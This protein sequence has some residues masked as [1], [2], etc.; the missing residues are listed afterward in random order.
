MPVALDYHSIYQFAPPEPNRNVDMDQDGKLEFACSGINIYG[1]YGPYTTFFS[2]FE[3]TGDNS[4][5]EVWTD[6]FDLRYP[7]AVGYPG[8][9]NY[10]AYD[11]GIGDVDGDGIDE[12]ICMDGYQVS[13]FKSTGD[14]QYQEI[15][16]LDLPSI[17]GLEHYDDV[18]TILCDV[19]QNGYAEIVLSLGNSDVVGGNYQTYIYEICGQANFGGLTAV[20]R[21][22][23]VRVEWSTLSQYANRGFRLWRAVGGDYGY[24]VVYETNDTVKLSLDTLRYS[25]ND[26]SVTAGLLYYYKVQAKALNTDSIFYGPVSVVYVGVSGQPEDRAPSFVNRLCPNAPNPFT[27]GTVIRYQVKDKA[28]VSLKVYNNNGQL[29]RALIDRKFREPGE[30]AVRWNGRNDFGHEVSAGVYYCQL[31]IGGWVRSGKMVKLR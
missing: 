23:C 6:S 15:H 25:F 31:N 9:P 11:I 13:V 21:D 22:S 16:R 17:A 8:C 26:S 28:M 10:V 19:N 2:L 12:M 30:Y 3:R 1:L 18:R 5:T 20:S 27:R 24:S 14:N 4:F 7:S 29:V